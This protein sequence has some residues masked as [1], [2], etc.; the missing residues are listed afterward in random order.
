M[1]VIRDPEFL[2]I[3][4]G[5]LDPNCA[6]LLLLHFYMD[7]LASVITHPSRMAECPELNKFQ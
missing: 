5:N 6:L 7:T 4:Q 2:K 3:K 1:R